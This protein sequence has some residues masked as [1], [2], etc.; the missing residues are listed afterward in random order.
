[1]AKYTVE[2][3]D[4]E[5]KA[6]GVIS[7]SVQ[8]WIDN[9]VH[10]RARIAIDE[11]YNVEVERMTADPNIDSIPADKDAVVLAANIKSAKEKTDEQLAESKE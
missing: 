8:D 1:M 6:M 3:T 11:I 9:A 2:L 4:S 10:N 7:Y 5:V